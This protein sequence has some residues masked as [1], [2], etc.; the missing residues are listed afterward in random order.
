VSASGVVKV[1]ENCALVA[2]VTLTGADASFFNSRGGKI[3]LW[4]VGASQAVLDDFG[5]GTIPSRSPAATAVGGTSAASFT[6]CSSGCRSTTCGPPRPLH[7]LG[8][9]VPA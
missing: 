6:A 7:A 9:A 1:Y 8:E 3:G 4:T 5:G 2:T